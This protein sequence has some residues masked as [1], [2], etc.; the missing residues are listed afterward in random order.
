MLF[1]LERRRFQS[2]PHRLLQ[3][4]HQIHVVNGLAAGTFQ[5]VVDAGD[6]EQLVAVLL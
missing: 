5:Q 3:V 6:D 2:Q 4:K 1:S